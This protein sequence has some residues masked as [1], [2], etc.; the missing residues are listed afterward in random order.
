MGEIYGP[1]TAYGVAALVALCT[2]I[3]KGFLKA[4]DFAAVLVSL[5]WSLVWGS[6]FHLIV[7][8]ITPMT[9]YE[10]IFYSFWGALTANGI[11]SATATTV[12]AVQRRR[13]RAALHADDDGFPQ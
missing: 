10:A 5:F 1:V 4:D 11:Y 8:G 3:T 7:S 13:A 2:Q 12:R 9:V 6:T